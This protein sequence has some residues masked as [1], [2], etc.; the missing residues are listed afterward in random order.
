MFLK[1]VVREIICLVVKMA[2][3]HHY[4]ESPGPDMDA[5]L[6]TVFADDTVGWENSEMTLFFAF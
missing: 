3:F 4:Y 1:S 5:F 2:N 6:V